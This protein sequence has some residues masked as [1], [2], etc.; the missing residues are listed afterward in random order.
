MNILVRGTNWIGD[1]VMTIPA[2][3]KLRRLFPNAKLTLQTRAWAE[4]IFREAGLFDEVITPGSLIEQ[5]RTLRKH[6]FDLAIIFPNSF[7]SALAA[8]LGG[9][10][11]IFGYASEGRSFLL[12]D[13]IP[14]PLWKETRHEVYYYL[15]LVAA[16]ERSYFGKVTEPID[17]EPRFA[18]STERRSYGRDL[19]LQ[20]GINRTLKTIAL[21][22]GSTNSRA[23]RWPAESFARLNDM[24]QEELGANVVL[25]GSKEEA[26]VSRN[27]VELSKRAPYDLT[28]TTDLTDAAAL[29]GEV[30]LLISND[31][32]LAHLAPAVGTKTLV[33]FGPTNPVTT[34]PLSENASIISAGVECSP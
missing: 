23:K 32:G 33:I 13:S 17:L 12:T 30:D 27:V 1:T 7:V 22:P 10:R 2:V 9:A 4:G 15:E 19:L 3:R 5:V 20:G 18:M 28:G 11:R 31:M 24:L 29:L 34:R 8:R 14:V 6:R 26:D 21:A 25:L 16:V